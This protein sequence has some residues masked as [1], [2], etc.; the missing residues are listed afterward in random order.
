MP[1]PKRHSAALIFGGSEGIGFAI[2][3]ALAEQG[4]R[5]ALL[6]RDPEK[7]AP[8]RQTLLAET[9]VDAGHCLV[10]SVDVTDEAAVKAVCTQL[11][12]QMGDVSLV[13]SAA[14]YTL[15]GY[16]ETLTQDDYQSQWRH[17]CLGMIHVVQVMLPYFRARGGGQFVGTSSLLG[18]MGMFG[19]SAYASSKFA[20]TGYL[21]SLRAEL[22]PEKIGVTILCPPAVDT[23]GFAKENLLKPA[24]VLKAEERAGIAQPAQLAR[25][26]LRRLPENPSLVLPTFG[27]RLVY[28]AYRLMPSL[29]SRMLE[30]P[31]PRR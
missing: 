4:C 9:G 24:E 12:S 11:L 21:L 15:P 30:K 7:L 17:N 31:A 8:A 5:L 3:K 28:L 26:L 1:F 2:A 25:C 14:G 6:S 10:A 27:A 20:L 13:V 19:Y 16:V 29:V 23:P 22:A 18:L